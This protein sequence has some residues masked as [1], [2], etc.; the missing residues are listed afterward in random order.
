[1]DITQDNK[2][3]DC[4]SANAVIFSE[5]NMVIFS[6]FS[7]DAVKRLRCPACVPAKLQ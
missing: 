1:M 6:S 3:D 4:V 5:E 2:K 7:L